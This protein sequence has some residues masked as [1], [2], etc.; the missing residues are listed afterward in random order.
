MKRNLLN[1]IIDTTAFIVLLGLTATGLIMQYVLP[2]GTGGGCGDGY[3]SGFRGG[4]GP[5]CAKD[6]LSMTRHQ[7]GD[8]HYI[9]AVIFI[10][11]ILVHIILHFSWIKN[12]FKSLFRCEQKN[13]EQENL[14]QSAI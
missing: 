9:L 12:C 11:L 5:E 14:P 1:F 6:L 7:W 3:G 10:V 2:P 4:R 13:G 8:V